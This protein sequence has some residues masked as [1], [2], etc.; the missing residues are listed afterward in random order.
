M[1]TAPRSALIEADGRNA[2]SGAAAD[3]IALATTKLTIMVTSIP[4]TQRLSFEPS[5]SSLLV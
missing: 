2:A 4:R 1:R 3:P 5:T